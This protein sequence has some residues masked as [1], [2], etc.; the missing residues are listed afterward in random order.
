MRKNTRRNKTKQIY[1]I[2]PPFCKEIEVNSIL[3]EENKDE[4]LEGTV[5]QYHAQAKV[6]ENDVQGKVNDVQEK[7]NENDV[8]GQVKVKFDERV[9]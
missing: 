9:C 5:N 4:N 7:V 2:P 8:Q 1:I 3:E 6:I